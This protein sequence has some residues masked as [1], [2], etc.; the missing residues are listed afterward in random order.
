MT[1]KQNKHLH[2]D[3]IAGLIIAVALSKV[4]TGD[5]TERQQIN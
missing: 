4:N 3:I 1:S 5:Q 2:N